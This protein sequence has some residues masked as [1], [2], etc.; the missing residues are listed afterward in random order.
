MVGG[1]SPGKGGSVHLNL[2][3]FNSVKEVRDQ[4][5]RAARRA[6]RCGDRRGPPPITFGCAAWGHSAARGA[7]NGRALPLFGL[8]AGGTRLAQ[9]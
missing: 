6:A 2:P 1:V 3:V 7:A 9:C 8:G 5:L 4:A